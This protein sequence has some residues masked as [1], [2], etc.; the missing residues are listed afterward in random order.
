MFEL[1]IRKRSGVT[2]EGLVKRDVKSIL[3]PY[4]EKGLLWYFMPVNTNHRGI[5]DF[6]GVCN[7]YWFSIET[8]AGHNKTTLIQDLIGGEIKKAGGI[9][10]VIYEDQ[11]HLVA[12]LIKEILTWKRGKNG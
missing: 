6:I 9:H 1:K 8:K 12:E 4:K 2:P 11:V 3:N 10:L 7:G 5:P